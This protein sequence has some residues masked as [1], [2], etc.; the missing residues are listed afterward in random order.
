M[1]PVHVNVGGAWK[2][3]SSVYTKIGGVWKTATDMPVRVGGVWKTGVLAT[4]SDFEHIQTIT[5]GA[6]GAASVSF[7]SIPQTYK[8]LQ[9]RAIARGKSGNAGPYNTYLTFN[10][11]AANNY[12]THRLVGDGTSAVAYGTSSRANGFVFYTPTTNDAANIF[13]AGVIDIL[14]YAST[15]KNKTVRSIGGYDQNGAG[16]VNFFSALWMS[17]NA[18]TSLTL[19]SETAETWVKYSTF[20][21]YGIK[22]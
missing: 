5:V 7:S 17:T 2:Q 15:S 13:G 6:G 10:G 18:I 22:G 8:H 12:A 9:I 11:D 19:T 1:S 14:D 4:P 20:S 21:L 16:W 3:A